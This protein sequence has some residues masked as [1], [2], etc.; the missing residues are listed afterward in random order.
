M[1]KVA[2]SKSLAGS[3]SHTLKELV[4]KN[5]QAVSAHATVVNTSS[6]VDKSKIKDTMHTYTNGK[7]SFATTVSDFNLISERVGESLPK[8]ALNS[9]NKVAFAFPHQKMNLT[10][11]ELEQR[12][13]CAMENIHSLGLKKGDRV[14]F[15]LPNCHELLVN[16]VAA[17]QLGLISVMLNPAYQSVEFEYMLNKTNCKALFIFDSFKTLNHIDMINKMCPELQSSVPGELKAKTLPD[18]RHVVVLN[19]PFSDEKKA[20]KGTWQFD[21][22]SKP[23]SQHTNLELPYI[24]IEDPCVILFTSGTTGTILLFFL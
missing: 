8:H 20:Y 14:A 17:S 15:A 23:R 21:Q 3:L 24:D 18:L 11:S 1:F 4:R 6:E 7:I 2:K 9:P 19:S 10:F 22:L 16:F 13:K 12:V 5:S